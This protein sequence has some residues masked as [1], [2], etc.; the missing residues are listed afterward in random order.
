MIWVEVVR[1]LIGF[2]GVL[3]VFWLSLGLC[4][5]VHFY[6]ILWWGRRSTEKRARS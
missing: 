1:F 2:V 3:L 5:V 4:L 6:L